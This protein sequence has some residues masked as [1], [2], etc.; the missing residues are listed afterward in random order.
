MSIKWLGA[1]ATAVV[2][3]PVFLVGSD[4]PMPQAESDEV[5]TPGAIDLSLPGQPGPATNQVLGRNELDA[6]IGGNVL[7]NDRTLCPNGRGLIQSETSVAVAG[8][9]VVA[10]FNDSRGVCEPDT[11]AAVGW[12]FSL[13][14]GDTWTDGG[15]LPSSRQ[16]NNG[17][18]WVAA[19]PDG[20]TFYLT[21]LYNGYQGF[22]FYRGTVTN[23]G[24]DWSLATV[25]QFGSA[26]HDKEAIAVNPSTGRIHLTYTRFSA[27]CTI[28]STYSDDGGFTWNPQV[29]V[30]TG[31]SQ[32]SMPALD[33]QGNLY[34]AFNASPNIRV[35]KSTDGGDSFQSVASFGFSTPGV[36]FMDRSSD[37]PQI[38]IDT[39]GGDL[40]GWV[41]VVWHNGVANNVNVMISHSEDGGASWSTPMIVNQDGVASYHW[42]GSVSV[43]AN[44]TVNVIYLDR[45]NS[46]GT[47]LTDCFL[48]QSTDGATTFT[49]YQVTDLTSSW[50]GIMTDPGFTYAGDYIRGVTQG[51]SLYA[52]WA[53]P[54]NGDP[55]VYFSRIDAPMGA[56]R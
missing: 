36:P 33:G 16:L 12:A 9:V 32:G 51:T 49:D 17:D 37:F 31:S 45:R 55:D 10:A 8:N 39:S 22:G 28:C 18:P 4:A 6:A 25:V 30:Y 19:S 24:I 7:V 42:W 35:Y 14:N 5:E 53:D 27:P 13:D 38:A 1:A 21:G 56:R 34:V 11:H 29:P 46:P 48:S 44:G 41:Y 2:M 15:G 3:L 20:Q 23:T 43:D 40:D 52:T 54:R 26:T 50:Q 47:G